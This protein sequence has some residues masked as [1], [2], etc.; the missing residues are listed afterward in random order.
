MQCKHEHHVIVKGVTLSEM[1][2]FIQY[3]SRKLQLLIL[4]L[5]IF[6]KVEVGVKV[7]LERSAD[8]CEAVAVDP[9]RVSTE[10]TSADVVLSL[11]SPLLT[12]SDE[13][14]VEL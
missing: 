12:T 4:P 2:T 11:E 9:L 6:C 1:N 10:L 3:H 7:W 8:H 5:A 14:S 13:G